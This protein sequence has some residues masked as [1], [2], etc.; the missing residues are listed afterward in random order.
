MLI[1]QVVIMRRL[2]LIRRLAVHGGIRLILL[3]S[4]CLLICFGGVLPA[5]TIDDLRAVMIN[6]N[7]DVRD[8]KQAI[9][10]SRNDVSRAKAK[11][12]PTIKGEALG[13]YIAN[14][15]DPVVVYPDELLAGVDWPAGMEPSTAGGPVELY[16]G[17]E[18]TYYQFKLSVTQP[19]Y[20]WGK[21]RDSIELYGKTV[22]I[23]QLDLEMLLDELDTK[24]VIY[25]D[26]LYYLQKIESVVEKQRALLVRL[27][28]LV[29]QN[30]ANGFVLKDEVL[31]T[32]VRVQQAELAAAQV[33]TNMDAVVLELQRMTGLS[34]LK[35]DDIWYIP[36]TSMMLDTDPEVFADREEDVLS[37]H[38]EVLRISDMALSVRELASEISS[39]SVYWKP[40]FALRLDVGYAGSR[41]PFLETDWYRQ[42][43]Y[44][45]NATVAIQT[46]I[47]DGGEKFLD[48]SDSE[49]AVKGAENDRIRV[50]EELLFSFRHA[51]M[52]FSLLQQSASY[53]E[54]KIQNDYDTI[55]FK[56]QQFENGVGSESDYILAQLSLYE[57]RISYLQTLIDTSKEYHT[58]LSLV[59]L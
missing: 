35:V 32:K 43:D 23:K 2:R 6:Q 8:K 30:F 14:P 48:I 26:T 33:K 57:D 45:L 11:Q 58:L 1:C 22:D 55:D 42:D 27:E 36:E 41:F 40:D 21:I 56:Q 15:I 50:K 16:G 9:A 59:D 24:L 44:S 20:T 5:Y 29:E 25:L 28:D 4:L 39:N 13:T 12:F 19:V 53:Y 46:T 34:D 10:E 38:Q 3:L 31:A 51:L 17:Q 52:Q 37:A 54:A 18:P 47:W 49:L 7:S